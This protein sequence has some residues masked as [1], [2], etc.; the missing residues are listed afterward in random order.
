MI[1]MFL[2]LGARLV[3]V[4]AVLRTDLQQKAN[5]QLP[6]KDTTQPLR[7]RVL[8]RNSV[9][10]AETVPAL[11]CYVDPTL[12]QNKRAAAQLLASTLGLNAAALEKKIRATKGSFLWI[13]RNVPAHYV[14]HIKEQNMRGISFKTEYR[15]N[16]PQGPIGS[17]LLGMVG[18]EGTG[19]SGVEQ[20]YERTLNFGNGS[21]G[22]GDVQ[23]TID[24]E[25][26]KIVERELFWGAG[27]EHRA[28]TQA[29]T[30]PAH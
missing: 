24:S 2:I 19:L 12:L 3:Y 18:Y 11:S 1:S 26:Q 5:R 21:D 10:L 17:H 16:Y 27:S 8:D 9:V 14:Q 7:G 13:E 30:L 25:I 29:Q 15:R 23:L 28:A 22:H 6:S 4:Q 20:A